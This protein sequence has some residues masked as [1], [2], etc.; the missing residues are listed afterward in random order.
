MVDPYD[1]KMYRLNFIT[2]L[3]DNCKQC[4]IANIVK[5]CTSCLPEWRRAILGRTLSH[6]TALVSF[7]VYFVLKGVRAPVFFE[8]F[9]RMR[10]K[11]AEDLSCKIK[12]TTSVCILMSAS[13]AISLS[14]MIMFCLKSMSH[15]YFLQKDILYCV[16]YC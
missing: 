8:M 16:C 3:V 4:C 5:T 6:A 12:V 15:P 7:L 11:V 10:F 1:K 9:F 14:C 2:H 13:L